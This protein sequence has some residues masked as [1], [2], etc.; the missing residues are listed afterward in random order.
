MWQLF[1]SSSASG[2]EDLECGLE[3]YLSLE[4]LRPF[5]E[6]FLPADKFGDDPELNE[7]IKIF[8]SSDAF[9][10]GLWWMISSPLGG[11]VFF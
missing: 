3:V 10:E 6:K 9:I 5:V 7:Q 2:T 1:V 11:L 8:L 4:E